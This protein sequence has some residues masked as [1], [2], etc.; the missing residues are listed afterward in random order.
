MKVY[1]FLEVYH[2][3]NDIMIIGASI[4]NG[5]SGALDAWELASDS[6]RRAEIESIL[7]YGNITEI[8]IKEQGK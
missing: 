2:S 4:D 5:Y 7:T 3:N 1:E 8:K 6:E